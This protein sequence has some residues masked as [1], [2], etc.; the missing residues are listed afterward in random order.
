MDI[1]IDS[2]LAIML[3]YIYILPVQNE[4]LNAIII[5]HQQKIHFIVDA[6]NG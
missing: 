3:L 4:K 1:S 2:H 6:G 5:F